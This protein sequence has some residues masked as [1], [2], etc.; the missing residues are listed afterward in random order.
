MRFSPGG[1]W[2]R[3]NYFAVNSSYSNGY[4]HECGGGQYQM[5]N[6]IVIEGKSS[7][8]QS[9]N[10]LTMPPLLPGSNVDRFDSVLGNT[11]GSDVIMVYSNKK[12]YPFYL[13]TYHGV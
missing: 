5:F 10:Q 1:M 4:R 12:A 9:N 6:A 11:N 8:L 3:A 7:K 13:I 2:G